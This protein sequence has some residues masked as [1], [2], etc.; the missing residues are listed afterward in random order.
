MSAGGVAYC[1][2]C[3]WQACLKAGC[4]LEAEAEALDVSPSDLELELSGYPPV[5]PV[6]PAL[7]PDELEELASLLKS[8]ELSTGGA[9]IPHCIE[10]GAP[11]ASIPAGTG[12][13]APL[14]PRSGRPP[15]SQSAD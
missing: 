12:P 3:G 6:V 5:V 13:S 9:V 1:D 7:S 2:D 14:D 4:C 8:R 15:F 10:I 11:P